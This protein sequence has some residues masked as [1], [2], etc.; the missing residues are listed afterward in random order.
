MISQD[1]FD[2]FLSRLRPIPASE[3]V[4]ANALAAAKAMQAAQATRGPRPESRPPGPQ[5]AP[6]MVARPSQRA[7][8]VEADFPNLTAL[9]AAAQ[10]NR[11]SVQ[12]MVL[13]PDAYGRM[14]FA[15][16][17]AALFSV[18]TRLRKRGSASTETGGVTVSGSEI[19]HEEPADL[20]FRQPVTGALVRFEFTPKTQPQANCRYSFVDF[21]TREVTFTRVNINGQSASGSA[22]EKYQRPKS[23]DVYQFTPT[24]VLDRTQPFPPEFRPQ[25]QSKDA[26]GA[27]VYYKEDGPALTEALALEIA[28]SICRGDAK[29]VIVNV[30]WTLEA[31][32]C[33]V[34]PAGDGKVTIENK[35]TTIVEAHVTV[36]CLGA[37]VLR[38]DGASS[39]TTFAGASDGSRLAAEDKTAFRDAVKEYGQPWNN[40][41]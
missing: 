39:S 38:V 25:G 36:N 41:K 10:A 15:P 32:L 3:T 27:D 16:P 17:R 4:I 2:M 33:Q 20:P 18:R 13:T 34:C 8:D 23:L 1:D 35:T 14:M 19:E 22:D 28:A 21:V 29:Y 5:W 11:S 6:E 24:M 7:A 26:A 30:K 31:Y 37:P 40:V 9:D 12:E